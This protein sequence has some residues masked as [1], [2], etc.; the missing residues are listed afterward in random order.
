M[1]EAAYIT[2]ILPIKKYGTPS[3]LPDFREYTMIQPQFQA[4]YVGFTNKEVHE[5]CREYGLEY[6]EVKK[7]MTD[8]HLVRLFRYTIPILL[9]R[10]YGIKNL[11]IIG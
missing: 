6:A 10:Q 1:I 4:E 3:A 9:Y 8:I 11:E 2:G 5:L 7:G